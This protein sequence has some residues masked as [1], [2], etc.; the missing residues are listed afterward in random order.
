MAK[1]FIVKEED[2]QIYKNELEEKEYIKIKGSE[3]KHIQVLRYNVADD[4][5]VNNYNCKIIDIK[6]EYITLEILSITQKQGEPNINVNLYIGML[7]G[8]KMDFVVQKATELGVSKIVPFLSRNVVVKLDD[9][10]KIKKQ[11]KYKK[12]VNE[13]CKQCGRSDSV[14][15]Q[16]IMNL[17]QLQKHINKEDITI[18]AY[19]KEIEKLYNVIYKIKEETKKQS[20][21]Q[22]EIKEL[23]NVNVIIGPEGGFDIEEI[24]TFKNSD[25]N[26]S[27]VSLGER[28]LRAETAVINLLSIVMY[29]FDR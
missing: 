29:E 5:V 18:F 21:K 24:N 14:E 16:N 6:K 9:K 19:E 25:L 1:K 23:K 15:T 10:A 13:A 2:M 3:V 26:I 20:E 11:E 8:E 17:K 27:F 28:I 12:I 22:E 4:I 7:K